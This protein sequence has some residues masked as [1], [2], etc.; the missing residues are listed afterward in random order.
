MT[1]N[2]FLYRAGWVVKGFEFLTIVWFLVAKF[3]RH[4]WSL[5]FAT[6]RDMVSRELHEMHSCFIVAVCTFVFHVL[7]SEYGSY[8]VTLTFGR[9]PVIRLF[10][11]AMMVHTFTYVMAVL[12]LHLLRGCAMSIAAHRCLILSL[13]TVVVLMIQLTARG[14][15]DYHE[16]KPLYATCIWAINLSCLAAI[17]KYPVEQ[18]KMYY[19]NAKKLDREKRKEA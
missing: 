1:L 14:Y 12:V 16:L 17:Y 2:E 4:R 7:G 15:F 3:P 18:T 8:I 10:Y 13:C 6:K 11:L 9:I 5:F 19:K